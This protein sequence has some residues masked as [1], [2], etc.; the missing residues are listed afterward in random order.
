MDR[1]SRVGIFKIGVIWRLRSVRVFT[2]L[3]MNS[4]KDRKNSMATILCA[5]QYPSLTRTRR[6]M[7]ENV[8]HSVC[9]ADDDEQLKDACRRQAFDV[10]VIEETVPDQLKCEWIALL[11]TLGSCASVLEL[12]WPHRLPA[13][14]D[15][16]AHYAVDH[17][18]QF[19][20]AIDALTKERRVIQITSNSLIHANKQARYSAVGARDSVSPKKTGTG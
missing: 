4:R 5:G 20:A 11:R 18:R 3:G 19:T 6:I 14:P 2:K 1:L 8:G 10:A 15:A 13:A 12:Y 17:P 7:L 16:D 9:I